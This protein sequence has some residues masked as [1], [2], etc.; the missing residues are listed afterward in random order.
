M[1][2]LGIL[3]DMAIVLAAALLGGII[4]RRL[5]LP[6]IIGYILSGV[7]IGPYGLKLVQDVKDVETLATI[8]VVLLMFTIGMEFSFKVLRDIG[9][10]A[11]FGGIAQ[12]IATAAMGFGAG[13]L[14]D[15]SITESV[16]FGFFIAMSSTIIVLKTL[17]ERGELGTPHGRVMLGILLVQDLSVVPIIIILPS[18]GEGA[19]T[20]FTGEWGWT[21]LKAISFL[22]AILVLGFWFLPW[23]MRR[24][25][26]GRARE[27]FLLTVVCL[28]FG[29]AFG[30]YYVGLSVALGAF[31]AGL[32]VSESPYAHQS[33]AEI[34]PLRD[35]FATLFFVSL[36]MLADPSFT[37]NNITEIAIIVTI[38][39]AGKFVI[40]SAVTWLFGYSGKTTLFASSGLFQIGE[41]SFI[42]AALALETGV[43]SNHVYS[44]TLAAAGITILL[45]PFAMGLTSVVYHNLVQNK[46]FSG[47]FSARVDI[48][49]PDKGKKLSNHVVICG[50]GRTAEN[51]VRVLERRNFP[52]LVIDIDPRV[53]EKARRNNIPCIYGDTSNPHILEQAGLDRARVLVVTVPDPIASELA[54]ENARRINRK[55]DIVARVHRD[56]DVEVLREKGVTEMVR[57]ELEAGLEI[58]RHTLH[59][60]GLTSQE[61]QYVVNALRE[62]EV[63]T[64]SE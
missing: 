25:A 41:F 31:L 23:F 48:G 52:Y 14:F 15:W 20:V 34:G 12:I 39:V 28:C 18:L 38:I 35:L 13:R 5:K 57:P 42:I 47:L 55:L 46:R 51:L 19:G 32:M 10:I 56:E 3:G 62:E 33:R 36:G 64:T 58:I 59:R 21:I 17:M 44:V 45:T 53:I 63:R 9:R 49:S 30:A 2:E 60:F 43:I 16:L 54:V 1:G 7:A 37:V 27:L 24:V 8:G 29:A 26:E 50:Y 4:A 61:I 6:I 11:V 40:V 22:A